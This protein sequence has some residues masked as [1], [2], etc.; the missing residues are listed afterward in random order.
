MYGPLDTE[1]SHSRVIRNSHR[2]YLTYFLEVHSL[3]VLAIRV[4]SCVSPEAIEG[5]R[6]LA[7]AEKLPSEVLR[8]KVRGLDDPPE[9]VVPPSA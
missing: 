2:G 9:P 6:L 5:C 1:P 3:G 7:E 4:D 8:P